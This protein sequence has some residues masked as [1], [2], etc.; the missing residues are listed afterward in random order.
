MTHPS[1]AAARH[2]PA[3]ATRG[4]L[5]FSAVDEIGCYF[6]RPG[7]P[8]NVHAEVHLPGRLDPARLREAVLGALASRPRACVRRVPPRTGDRRFRWELAG[9]PDVDLLSFGRW[10]DDAALAREREEFLA[11]APSLDLAPPLRIRLTSGPELDVL[12]LN[13]HHSAMDGVSC[14]EMVRSI[15]RCYSGDGEPGDDRPAP[16]AVPEP[17]QA[18]AV[19]PARPWTPH[20]PV[21]PARIAPRTATPGPGYGY[22]LAQLARPSQQARDRLDPDATVNDILIATLGVTVGR[23][24]AACGRPAGTVQV[25]MPIN[26]RDPGFAPGQIGNMTRLAA[27]AIDPEDRTAPGRLIRRVVAQTRAAKERPGS[28]IGLMGPVMAPGWLPVAAKQRIAT[29]LR[30]LLTS[31]TDTAKLSNWGTFREPP[32]FGPAG[33]ARA[34]WTSG[35][36]P[37]PRGLSVTIVTVGDRPHLTLRYRHALFDAAGAAA[38]IDTYLGAYDDVLSGRAWKPDAR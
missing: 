28:P 33:A 7:E 2:V 23:W 14:L 8:N 18:K 19:R 9:A 15:A 20:L 10:D 12:I 1:H 22:R 11:L 25:T 16:A 3:L 27:I 17:G 4:V 26:I 37:M 38:F 5:P 21:R 36:G 30:R 32:R 34:V 31:Y 29:P 24:N 35:P 13:A 6:D